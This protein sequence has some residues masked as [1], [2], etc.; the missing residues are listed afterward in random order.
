MKNLQPAKFIS[1]ITLCTVLS[2]TFAST[3]IA[4]VATTPVAEA[5]SGITTF[6]IVSII[7][8]LILVV[9]L[10]APYFKKPDDKSKK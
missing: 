8:S 10:A 2:I 1:T 4:Q 6:D 9:Y 3:A 7:A 5:S